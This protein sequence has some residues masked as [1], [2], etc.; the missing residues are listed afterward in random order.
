MKNGC[1]SGTWYNDVEHVCCYVYMI[2]IRT[3]LPT[4]YTP[5]TIDSTLPPPSSITLLRVL[6]HVRLLDYCSSSSGVRRQPMQ[7]SVPFMMRRLLAH[8]LHS[9][10]SRTALMS[11]HTIS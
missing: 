8:R 5:H 4:L 3:M 10:V 7:C 2:L 6:K 11:L 1:T 9:R